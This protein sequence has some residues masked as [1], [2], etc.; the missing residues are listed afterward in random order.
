MGWAMD[1]TETRRRLVEC[2]DFADLC[3][4]GH[5]LKE[6]V[7]LTSVSDVAFE[8]S[9]KCIHC[10]R[11]LWFEN[12]LWRDGGIAEW[13]L[14]QESSGEQD[15]ICISSR[16]LKPVLGLGETRVSTR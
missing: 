6:A 3:R 2:G 15:T 16:L 11:V 12:L 5:E 14:S 10:A 4:A 8:I 7:V 1:F 9:F 13:R